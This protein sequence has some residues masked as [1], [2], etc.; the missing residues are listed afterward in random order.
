VPI[1]R[2]PEDTTTEPPALTEV[3]EAVP[4]SDTTSVP[5]LVTDAPV[6]GALYRRWRVGES[7]LTAH[8]EHEW[9]A[10]QASVVSK[11]DRAPYLLG[12]GFVARLLLAAQERSDLEN[13]LAG[14]EALAAVLNTLLS[15]ARAQV[16]EVRGSTSWRL[17]APLRRAGRLLAIARRRRHPTA[18]SRQAAT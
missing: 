3:A 8:A 1:A 6:V 2:P 4:P 15:D 12:R 18:Q 17:T 11:L 7:S 10:A 5:L 16:A 9:Q 14:T 13:R